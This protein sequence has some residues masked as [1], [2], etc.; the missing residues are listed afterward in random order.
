VGRLGI[1][2]HAEE[3]ASIARVHGR[4]PCYMTVATCQEACCWWGEL[5]RSCGG[6]MLH[7]ACMPSSRYAQV[8]LCRAQLLPATTVSCAAV[9]RGTLGLVVVLVMM[10]QCDVLV[11]L[12]DSGAAMGVGNAAAAQSCA[13]A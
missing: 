5:W 12:H 2:E 10:M 7:A 3:H 13:S 1:E 8:H 11:R 9:A 6:S 4:G